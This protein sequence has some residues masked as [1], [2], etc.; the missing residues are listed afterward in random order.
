MNGYLHVAMI[1]TSEQDVPF[2]VDTLH[3]QL[4]KMNALLDI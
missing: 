2:T 3:R 4:Y 1:P